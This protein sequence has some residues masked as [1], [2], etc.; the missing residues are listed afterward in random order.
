[1]KVNSFN[2]NSERRRW[3]ASKLWAKS[4]ENEEVDEK[5]RLS[6]CVY[7]LLMEGFAICLRSS[8][9]RT[10]LWVLLR[11]VAPRNNQQF[12]DLSLFFLVSF[13]FKGT[14]CAVKLFS[15][16]DLPTRKTAPDHSKRTTPFEKEE[17]WLKC[18]KWRKSIV[19][20]HAFKVRLK[21][22]MRIMATASPG[23]WQRRR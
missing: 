19:F 20:P 1:M 12:G 4:K 13:H 21:W 18:A 10:Q 15:C 17:K 22:W 5:K 23:R 3:I 2:L 11:M 8:L 14:L 16:W 7:C 6:I 9:R